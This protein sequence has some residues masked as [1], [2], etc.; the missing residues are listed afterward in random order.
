MGHHESGTKLLGCTDHWWKLEFSQ[1]LLTQTLLSI[2]NTSLIIHIW[3]NGVIVLRKYSSMEKT[4]L[5]SANYP[6]LRASF[7]K[8]CICRDGIWGYRSLSH[9]F[10]R[11]I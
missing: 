3:L 6:M 10:G 5:K 2:E 9:A 1:T 8:Y 4:L 7:C 11:R